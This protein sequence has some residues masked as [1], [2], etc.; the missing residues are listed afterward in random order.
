METAKGPTPNEPRKTSI[1]ENNPRKS[2]AISNNSTNNLQKS[3]LNGRSSLLVKLHK[4]EEDFKKSKEKNI[5]KILKKFRKTRS[6]KTSS[7]TIR[8]K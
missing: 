8:R 4:E 6:G 5:K 1:A 3:S 7:I 2:S